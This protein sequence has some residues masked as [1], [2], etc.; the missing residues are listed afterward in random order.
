MRPNP[1]G[2]EVRIRKVLPKE[3]TFRLSANEISLV[4]IL[5]NHLPR[6][7]R[8]YGKYRGISWNTIYGEKKPFKLGR[9]SADNWLKETEQ[10]G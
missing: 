2:F 9:R 1:F 7:K 5:A 3:V 4:N 6:K 10:C 8:M